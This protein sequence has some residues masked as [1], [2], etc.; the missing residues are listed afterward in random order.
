MPGETSGGVG[1]VGGVDVVATTTGRV[2]G[3]TEGGVTAFKGVP[4]ATAARWA[5]PRPAPGWTGIRDALEFGPQAPQTPG[6]LEAA[7]G[8]ADWPMSEDCLSLNVWTPR[9]DP[10]ARRPVLVFLHGGAFTNGSG[11]GPWY[12]GDAFARDGCV[13]VTLNYRLGALGYL[14]LSDLAGERFAGSGNLGLLDQVAALDWVQA[15]IAGFGGDPGNVTVFGES[16]GGASVLALLACPAASGRFHRAIAE[17][18]SILQLRTRVEATA[19][20]EQVL[21]RLGIGRRELDRLDDVPVAALLDAQA[22]FVG[23]ELFT[24][25]APTPD[26]TVV[27]EPV[28]DGAGAS[29]TPVLIGTNRDEL[30]LFTALDGRMATVDEA[31][32]R[33][34]A[35]RLAGDGADSLIAAYTAARPGRV[36]GQL[37]ASIAGDDAFWL[38]AVG[39]A[40]ARRAPTWMYR[41]DWP[42]PVFGGVLGACHG[43]ELPFVFDTLDAAR[44]FIGD[45]PSLADLATTVHRTWVRFATT[46]DPG[47]STYDGDRRATLVFDTVSAVVDDP[48]GDLR[49]R[50]AATGASKAG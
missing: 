6:L 8:L 48:D 36:P 31:K 30:Y 10:G 5:P 3:R 17:S 32:L 23:P 40:E 44:G 50:W 11:A 26:G 25:F 47:W 42:T 2:A 4:Y 27:P 38:P 9:A 20:A 7:F 19:A 24:A 21:A 15:N 43:V 39:L 45:D 41:F 14:H 1:S 16:A 28:V 34:V 33:A 35:Q 12:H 46:G 29:T 49:T 22:A 13:L 18:P 37:G